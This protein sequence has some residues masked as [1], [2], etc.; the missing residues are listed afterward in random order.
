[1][2]QSET[3]SD[4]S[5]IEGRIRALKDELRKR[6]SVVDQLKKE[7]KKRQ[8]ERLKAQEAS[9][10][11]QLESY[12]EFIKKTETELSR[13]L[14]TSPTAKPQIKTLPSASEKP[15]I[16]PLQLHRSETAK[17]WKSLTDSERSRGSLESI[18]EHADAVLSSSERS[19]SERSLSACAKRVIELDSRTEERFQTSSPI[20]RSSP[21]IIAESGDSLDNVPLLHLLK[22]LNAPNSILGVSDAKAEEEASQKSETQGVKYA[23]LKGSGGR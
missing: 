4:Q 16:K 2:T 6:K 3:T 12:D 7:Q 19:V 8:K 22:E 9:L 11:K 17:N 13:D 21:K 1:M 5:D 15:K 10:I 14:E 23:K 18:A 20:L